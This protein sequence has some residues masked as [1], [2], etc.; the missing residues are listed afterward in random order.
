MVPGPTQ[1]AI[2]PFTDNCRGTK[3]TQAAFTIFYN[4]GTQR[5][6]LEQ[7]LQ[8]DEQMWIDALD[9]KPWA[10]LVTASLSREIGP[11]AKTLVYLIALVQAHGSG[12]SKFKR[13]SATTHPNGQLSKASRVVRKATGKTLRALCTHSTIR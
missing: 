11:A 13:T 1:S 3:P 2:A 6:D 9:Q 4:Q 5:Y 7:T 10:R 12:M 8:P